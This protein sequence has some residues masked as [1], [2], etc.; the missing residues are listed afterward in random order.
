MS[1]V[2]VPA[3]SFLS[4]EGIDA[5]PESPDFTGAIQALFTLSYKIKFASK[6]Q[7]DRDYTIMP[8]EAFW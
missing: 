1:L 2:D 6:K 3:F 7:M 8:L 4:I 5:R